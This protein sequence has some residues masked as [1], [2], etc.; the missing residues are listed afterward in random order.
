[1]KTFR[2]QDIRERLSMADFVVACRQAFELYGGGQIANPPRQETVDEHDGIGSFRLDMPAEWKGRY[3]ARKI[4]EETSDVR[5]GRLDKRE[6]Y[7]TL[8]DLRSGSEVRLDAGTI[9]DM[10]T[11]AAGGLAL[12][13][14][15][16][17]PPTRVAI[18]GTG[19]IARG[20]A[21]ACDELYD[22]DQIRCTSRAQASREA[23]AA[24]IGP[25]L[26]ADLAMVDSL[27]DCLDGVDA[28]L[29]AV[30]TPEPILQADD[31]AGIE[32]VAVVAG[33]SRTRQ[34]AHDLLVERPVVVDVLAQAQQ[35]GE[36]RWAREQG[37][38]D[39]VNLARGPDG[40]LDIGDAACG[41]TGGGG[42]IAYLTGMAAQDLC[43]AAMIY[44][45]Q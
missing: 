16:P 30:P 10:R 7:I 38:L 29:T 12:E 3:R 17:R 31:L 4:I 27:S 21:L 40:V 33:D 8:E 11:G 2:E 18:V 1:M 35:S 23:F 22:L 42:G 14:L 26:R 43:A 32:A 37:L 20:L 25:R 15:G 41:R 44:E 45:R 19:R 39:H 13:Y 28:A 24:A 36:F 9:T 5:S 6:A 34:I